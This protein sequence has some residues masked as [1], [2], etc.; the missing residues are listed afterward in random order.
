M[1]DTT[2]LLKAPTTPSVTIRENI[3]SGGTSGGSTSGRHSPNG[4]GP[5]TA[6]AAEDASPRDASA[7]ITQCARR[8]IQLTRGA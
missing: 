6:A 8:A 3:P 1:P 4:E 2:N 5:A 7:M